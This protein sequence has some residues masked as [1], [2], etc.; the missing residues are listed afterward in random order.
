[1]DKR[2][3]NNTLVNEQLLFYKTGTQFFTG[4]TMVTKNNVTPFYLANVCW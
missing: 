4:D 3:S 2:Q 1:M